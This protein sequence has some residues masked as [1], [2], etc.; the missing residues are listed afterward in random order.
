MADFIT[1]VVP[2]LLTV[3]CCSDPEYLAALVAGMATL[4]A[5]LLTAGRKTSPAQ[6]RFHE[7]LMSTG[8][9]HLPFVTNYRATALLT[10]AVCI[11]A[12]DFPVF[13]RRFA[14]TESFGYGLM[15]VGVGSFVFAA[16]LVSQEAR[17]GT[18]GQKSALAHVAKSTLE[19]VPLLVLGF[20]RLVAV[21][22]TDYHEHVSEYGVHWNF[23][24]TLAASK[25]DR[26][27]LF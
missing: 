6:P 10:T 9:G 8:G 18:T 12:V 26:T 25:V 13:P 20:A 17:K 23:F 5:V 11:L 7:E 24:F 22:S 3:T 21:K 2:F 1:L 14:K 4:T 27:L 15:D 19:C 16:G